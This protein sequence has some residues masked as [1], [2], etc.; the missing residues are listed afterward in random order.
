MA[1]ISIL[2]FQHQS[3]PG[4][5]SVNN[6][7]NQKNLKNTLYVI[8]SAILA[9]SITLAACEGPVGPQGPPGEPGIAGLQGQIGPAGAD[10][11]IMYAG[12]GDPDENLGETGDWYLDLITGNLFGPKTPEGW[13]NSAINLIG[14]P[15]NDGED[16]KDGTDGKDGSQIYAGDSDPDPGLG[17]PG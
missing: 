12:H 4:E 15:G 7:L 2:K 8:L 10:G 3:I 16:G 1:I 9:S 5:V 11:S 14:P 6:V 13:G 17:K